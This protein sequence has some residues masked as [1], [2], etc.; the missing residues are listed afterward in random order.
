MKTQNK[1]EILA[2]IASFHQQWEAFC[3]ELEQKNKYLMARQLHNAGNLI[4][5]GVEDIQVAT[6]EEEWIEKLKMIQTG[7]KE[8]IY[9]IDICKHST[10]NVD[11]LTFE[12]FLEDHNQSIRTTV[13]AYTKSLELV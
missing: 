3:K 4:K 6:S 2:I 5:N 13:S 12:R 10:E 8:A 7:I 9:W 11:C 1:K